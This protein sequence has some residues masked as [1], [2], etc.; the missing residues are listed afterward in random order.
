VDEADDGANM[1]PIDEMPPWEAF[2]ELPVTAPVEQHNPIQALPVVEAA[3]PPSSRTE[4]LK[5]PQV[6]LQTTPEGDV[7]HEVVQQLIASE[8][9]TALVREL[10]LQSQLLAREGD[11][12]RLG[13]DSESLAR[14]AT[15]DRLQA[16]LQAAGHAVRL[17]ISQTA[18]T[19]SPAKRHTQAVAARMDAAIELIHNDP[20]VQSL[21]RD[22]DAKIVPGSIQPI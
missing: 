20:L 6:P 14:P 2:D 16:A 12:W 17:Q 5:R 22:Y 8:A 7:W 3:L 9:V 18:V 21:M 13:V 1:P 4:V 15:C 11:V 19:D 10:A